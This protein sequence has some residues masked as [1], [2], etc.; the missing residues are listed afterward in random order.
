METKPLIGGLLI[1]KSADWTSHDVVAKLR[2][3]LKERRIGHTGTLDPFAT[4]LLIVCLGKATRLAQFLS[5]QD[6]EYQATM[7]LGFA[8]DTQDLTGQPISP[9]KTVPSLS[10]AELSPIL[11]KF[12]GAQYQTPPMF[13]AKKVAGE[14][15]Y[16][17]ARRGETVERKAVPIKIYNLSLTNVEKPLVA[18]TDGT[19][20]VEITVKCS[21]GTYIRTL[22][23]DIG[24]EMGYGAHLLR[25][26]RTAI[27]SCTVAQAISLDTVTG[28]MAHNRTD[29]PIV[30]PAQLVGWLPAKVLSEAEVSRVRLGQTLTEDL[31]GLVGDWWRL[32]DEEGTLVGMAEMLNSEE[33]SYLQ[34]RILF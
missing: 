27:G 33:S 34:P 10:A 32:L 11:A 9:I 19:M 8:T 2:N 24:N 6:K 22:A 15:L 17:L 25:L 16:T 5:N 21:S 4:G 23:H 12:I 14:A 30:A 20:D 31:L 18:N 3:L 29:L 28:T 26:R 7:R 1:D 13:S